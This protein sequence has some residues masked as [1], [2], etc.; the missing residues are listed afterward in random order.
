MLTEASL[1]RVSVVRMASAN[2]RAAS[3]VVLAWA[4]SSGSF[5]RMFSVGKGTPMIPVEAGKTSSVL[6]PA[7]RAA[8][9]QTRWHALIP[10]SPVAQ[11][12]L[13]AITRFLVNAAAAVVPGQA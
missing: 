11:L 4:T 2:R 6:A 10:A 8:S 9:L 7:S 3:P 5:E 13:A 12:A 1:A